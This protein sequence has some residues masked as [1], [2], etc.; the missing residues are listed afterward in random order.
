MSQTGPIR[1]YSLKFISGKYQGGQ[2]DLPEN[3]EIIVGRSSELDVVLVE[4]MVSR[5]HAKLT[6]AG[7][8]IYIQDLGSTNGTFVNGEKVKRSR[9]QEGDRI[10]IGTSIVKLVVTDGTMGKPIGGEPKKADD[11]A[12]G[13]LGKPLK[14][15]HVRTMSG[16]IAEI[17]LPDLM[18]LFSASKKSGVLVV[19]SEA[20]DSGKLFLDLGRVVYSSVNDNEEVAPLK[21]LM[22]ILM[23]TTGTFDMEPSE[24]RDFPQR[25]DMSTEGVLMEAM[26]MMDEFKRIENEI[27]AMSARLT[28]PQPMDKPLREL[29]PDE[30]DVFQSAYNL[31]SVEKV[32]NHSAKTDLDV[33]ILL[34]ELLKKGVLRSEA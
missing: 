34:I 20:G 8:Q 31:G 16:S 14:S 6:V 13:V 18:Q 26:R 29:S 19:R 4:E 12:S 23:W 33:G 25:I 5:R 10:L 30:L 15:T 3:K 28:V 24:Q 11:S 1:A 22:R 27:P 21:S 9:L 7:D 32:M 17:P 2:I